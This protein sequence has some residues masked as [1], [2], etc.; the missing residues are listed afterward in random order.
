MD[1]LIQV[2]EQVGAPILPRHVHWWKVEQIDRTYARLAP[3]SAGI[4]GECRVNAWRPVWAPIKHLRRRASR[5]ARPQ[6]GQATVE[7]AIVLAA[8]AI[9]FLAL[10]AMFGGQVLGW[11]QHFLNLLS[12]F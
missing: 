6:A 10:A 7:Y 12:S 11:F 9:I 2:G 1:N 8:F 5:M 3:I 4:C